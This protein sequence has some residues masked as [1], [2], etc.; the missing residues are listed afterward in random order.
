MSNTAL[1]ALMTRRQKLQDE[2]D[3]MITQPES[4]NISGSVSAT[5]RKLETLRKE[6]EVIDR[7]IAAA[8]G[9]DGIERSYPNYRKL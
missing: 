3:R 2:Y 9:S 7:Q 8:A 4:Y 6:I 1:K 5:N